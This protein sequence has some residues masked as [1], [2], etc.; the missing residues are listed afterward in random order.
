MREQFFVHVYELHWEVVVGFLS[1]V[2][3]VDWGV[4]YVD[5]ILIELPDYL[6]CKH[7]MTT[8]SVDANWN[9]LL[10]SLFSDSVTAWKVRKS[11]F[12]ANIW[13]WIII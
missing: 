9:Y 11:P 10:T 7:I 3:Y 1:G 8:V 6:I 12:A 4:F 2:F 5:W 13:N